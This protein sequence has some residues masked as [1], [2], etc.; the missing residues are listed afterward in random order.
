[1]RATSLIPYLFEEINIE[2]VFG[3]EQKL[4]IQN[5]LCYEI[6]KYP[7]TRVLCL[8]CNKEECHRISCYLFKYSS[9]IDCGKLICY[10]F[11]CYNKKIYTI[12]LDGK[13]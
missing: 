9:K 6:F 12:Q 2:Y 1:M 10:K 11:V 13:M 3:I 4:Y 7:N 5:K 8:N